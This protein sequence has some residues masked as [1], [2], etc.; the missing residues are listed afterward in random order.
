MCFLNRTNIIRVT[1][2]GKITKSINLLLVIPVE[3]CVAT[4]ATTP[5]TTNTLAVSLTD[6]E[7]LEA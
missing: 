3:I 7:P 5:F 4:P 6:L 1:N 2:S